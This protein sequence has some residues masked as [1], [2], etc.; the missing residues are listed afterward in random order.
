M[1]AVVI[2]LSAIDP[3]GQQLINHNFIGILYFFSFICL[4]FKIKDTKDYSLRI[5]PRGG[6]ELYTLEQNINNM[7]ETLQADSELNSDCSKKM[8]VINYRDICIVNL[9][10]SNSCFSPNHISHSFTFVTFVTFVTF[11]TFAILT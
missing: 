11:A 10:L 1:S 9:T 7:L 5:E 8:A 3:S 6:I 2:F 4:F